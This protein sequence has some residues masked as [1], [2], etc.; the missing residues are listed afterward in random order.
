VQTC[1]SD[2]QWGVEVG[3]ANVCRSGACAKDPKVV[4]TTSATFNG[5]LGGLAGAD[6]ICATYATKGGLGGT[7]M[8]WLSDDTGSPSTRFKHGGPYVLS[9]GVT[10]IANNWADLTSGTIRHA[11][12]LTESAGTPPAGTGACTSI[13]G[14]SVVWADTLE[15]G[16]EWNSAATCSNWSSTTGTFSGWAT[17]NATTN[18]SLGCNGGNSAA[19]GCGSTNALFCFQQ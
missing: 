12:N 1:G 13:L 6:K 4:F 19:I 8:A 11:I 10:L 17:W 9:D 15:N 7:Y 2:G 3:C 14:P 18:W 5:N 16:T